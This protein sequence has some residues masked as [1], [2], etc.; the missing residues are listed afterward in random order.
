MCLVTSFLIILQPLAAAMSNRS[1]DNLTTILSGWVFASR[2]TLSRMIGLAEG[3]SKKHFTTL[4]R[5]F[6]EA[7]WSRDALGRAVFELI[8][9]WLAEGA[10]FLAMDDTLARKRGLKVFGVGMHHDP[11]LSSRKTA[12]TNWG[13]SWVVLG[14]LVTFKRWPQRTFCLPILFR[15]Y[16]N[17]ATSAKYGRVHHTR[18]ELAIEMLRVVCG[19]RKQRRF[20][21]VAD[22]AYGGQKVLKALPANCDLTSRL[23]LDARIYGPA[24][25]HRPGSRGRPRVRGERLPT[26]AEMLEQRACRLEL[27][28]Y[29]R[30]DRVRAV[31][32]VGY[33][34]AVPGRPLRIVAVEPLSGGRPKQAFYSTCQEASAEQV[35]MWYAGRWSIEVTNHDSKQHLGFEEPQGWSRRAVERTAPTAMLLYSLIVLWY[36]EE[37]HARYRQLDRP[38]YTTKSQESFADMLITLRRAS[39]REQVLSWGLHGPGSQKIIET[40][41][42]VISFAA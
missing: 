19:W 13:H 39:V 26:P 30:H 38:W 15:L 35:L 1:F 37:G 12:I 32:A 34:H 16:L 40:L 14:V 5:L 22:S 27:Q 4:Y 33:L 29:G 31:D 17:K 18:P 23:L 42:N 10:I 24:P 8:E 6:A 25:A 28:I 2:H 11:L 9:P 21:V 36:V 7:S 3:G 41:E 20:H